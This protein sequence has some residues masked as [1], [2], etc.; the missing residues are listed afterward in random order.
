MGGHLNPDSDGNLPQEQWEPFLRRLGLSDTFIAV[1]LQQG[2]DMVRS[3]QVYEMNGK[4][5]LEHAVS[6][7]IRDPVKNRSRMDV[8]LRYAN[9]DGVFTQ[10]EFAAA[11]CWF[12][13]HP[14]VESHEVP[15]AAFN[16]G[17]FFSTLVLPF[18]GRC[19]EKFRQVGPM[20]PG[21]KGALGNV[22]SHY[23]ARPNNLANARDP[24]PCTPE[25]LYMRQDDVENIIWRNRF[26]DDFQLF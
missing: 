6:T 15:D 23:P 14:H 18:F 13:S 24:L 7:G 3:L 22:T 12:E 25:M 2:G 11:G 9:S 4:V 1:I 17:S 10:A 8:L 16:L 19:G 20:V 26:P 21:G 5:Q